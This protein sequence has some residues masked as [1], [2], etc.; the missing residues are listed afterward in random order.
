M[1]AGDGWGIRSQVPL[2]ET[3]DELCTVARDLGVSDSDIWLGA[4]ANEREIRQPSDKG[5]LDSYRIVHFA[6][7]GALAGELKV[8]S[9]PGLIFTPPGEATPDDDGYLSASE[10]AG[11]MLD[12]DWVILGRH[13]RR[14]NVVRH[15]KRVLLRRR[16]RARGRQTKY[17]L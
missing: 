3:A 4:R 16:P 9:E 10:I 11:L 13:R 14:R 2:P 15:G 12:A 1:S 6:A 7:H 17:F 8:D 5:Q